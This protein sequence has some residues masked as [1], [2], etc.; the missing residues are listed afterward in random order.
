M[1]LLVIT[2]LLRQRSS[3][4]L[5]Q[6]PPLELYKKLS[7]CQHTTTIPLAS[8]SKKRPSKKAFLFSAFQIS[9]ECLPLTDANLNQAL[10]SGNMYVCVHARVLV[11]QSCPTLCDPV[12][13]SS[14]VHGV[15]QARI[16]EWVAIPL[17][18]GSSRPRDRTQVSCIA[19]GLY[20]WATREAPKGSIAIVIF[21]LGT[22]PSFRKIE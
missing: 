18:R 5:P 3:R 6:G 16:V 12:D 8:G 7:C 10:F 13:C 11:A 20:H 1:A 22:L 21:G 15:L 17:S 4:W 14:S 9:Q 19:G 2:E